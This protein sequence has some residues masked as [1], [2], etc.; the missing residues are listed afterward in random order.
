MSN[1]TQVHGEYDP[2]PKLLASLE[3]QFGREEIARADNYLRAEW[4]DFHWD[5]RLAERAIGEHPDCVDEDGEPIL[6]VA[7]VGILKGRYYVTV[8]HVTPAR[9][10]A[11]IEGVTQFD[12]FEAA[13]A[14][15][16]TC[17]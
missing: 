15:F 10:F 11:A 7:I 17:R 5:G 14:A 2:Y 8:A 16:Q 9:E 6:L 13:V 3:A 12:D 1:P 4:A